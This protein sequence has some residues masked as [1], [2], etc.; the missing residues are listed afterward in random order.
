MNV[1]TFVLSFAVLATALLPAQVD[2][3][4]PAISPFRGMRQVDG[5]IE[6][7]VLDDTWFALESVNGVETA[8]LL[9]DAARLARH[10]AWKRITEDLPALFDAMG[11]EWQVRVDVEVRDLATGKVRTFEDVEMTGANRR[12]VKEAQREPQR[13]AVPGSLASP[14][15]RSQWVECR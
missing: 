2:P 3:D 4:G 11:V 12:R 5:G 9:K 10:S 15:A 13:L 6:V 8:R 7:Q 14:R 1:R